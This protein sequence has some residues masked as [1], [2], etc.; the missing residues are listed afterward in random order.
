MAELNARVSSER[1]RAWHDLLAAEPHVASTAGD[2]RVIEKIEK[3]FTEMGLEVQRHEFWAL[4]PRPVTSVLEIVSPEHR[5]LIV[6]EKILEEDLYTQHPALDPGWNAFSGNGDVTGEVVYAN[7][8][9][10][11]DFAKLAEMGVEV[12]GK[13]VIARYGGNFRGYKAKFAQRAGAVGLVIYTD[14]ADSGYSKGLLYPEGGYANDTCIE[15][16]SLLTALYSGDVLTPGVEA[17]RDAKRLSLEEADIPQI[18]VQ[19]VGYGAALEIMKRMVGRGVMEKGSVGAGWQGSL[20]VPYRLEGGAELRVRLKVEQDREIRQTAN[21]VGVLKGASEPER[22]VVLG[23]HHDA[24]GFGAADPLA[25]TITL[26]ESARV[27]SE[28]AREG[29]RPRRTVVFGAWGAEEYGIIG[30]TEWV[31]GNKGRLATDGVAYFNLDMA[32]MGVEFAAGSAPSIRRVIAEV[33][34]QVPQGRDSSKTVLEAWLS[35]GRDARDSSLPAFGDLGG[36]SD[37]IGFWC[38]V[39]VPSA[40]LSAGGS[41]GTSYHSIYDNLAWYRKVVGEDYEAARM[42]TGMAAGAASVLADQGLLGIEPQEAVG[43]FR[44]HLRVISA[45]GVAAGMWKAPEGTEAVVGGGEMELVA[46]P[47]VGVDELAERVEGVVGAAVKGWRER[48]KS[49]DMSE[50]ERVD[51]N[52][53]L[54]A[55]D[56]VWVLTEGFRDRPWYRNAF[57]APDR[58]SGYAAWVLPLLC[59]VVEDRD[60]A[61]IAGVVGVY[62]GILRGLEELV[63]VP[64]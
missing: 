9:R 15:R 6:K 44:R 19:P 23:C 39:G 31:E 41:A 14:P 52:A 64:G 11:E 51:L 17:T 32:A 21:V 25:G 60:S 59:R 49:G 46:E 30:S 43:E 54:M 36:G 20:P 27:L 53:R 7:Y 33:A 34:G 42:V 38:H 55:S 28:A 63:E 47:L 50:S 35:R 24:W 18:P 62:E 58:D 61:G 2:R 13:I 57:A 5:A 22:M 16:G 29:K 56:R 48:E 12:R 26:M 40:G 8:G 1:L 45:R 3:A 37:H 4:L 10:K